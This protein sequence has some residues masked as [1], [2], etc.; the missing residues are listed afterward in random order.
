MGAYDRHIRVRGELREE[1]N[2]EGY[3]SAVTALL[4]DSLRTVS[5]STTSRP[6]D[7]RNGKPSPNST[8]NSSDLEAS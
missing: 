1:M 8:P 4:L 6:N 5:E 7:K 3:A 2:I